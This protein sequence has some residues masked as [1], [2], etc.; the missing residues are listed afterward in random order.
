MRVA[1]RLALLPIIALCQVPCVAGAKALWEAFPLRA[2]PVAG[3]TLHYEA[4][5][6][7]GVDTLERAYRQFLGDDAEQ[8]RRLEAL[9]GKADRI[10][11]HVHEWVGGS[12]TD[13]ER[14][15]EKRLLNLLLRQPFP[16]AAAPQKAT[17]CLVTK[18]AVKDYLRKGGEL[19]DFGYDKASDSALY[20]LRLRDAS[21]EEGFR[22][23]VLA[24]GPDNVEAA[25]GRTLGQLAT[26][27]RRAPAV[28]FYEL[29]KST[30]VRRLRPRDP[31]YRWFAEGFANAVASRLLDAHVSKEA[32]RD[33]DCRADAEKHPEFTNEAN[34][35]HW[36]APDYAIEAP[37]EAE[38]RLTHARFAYATIEA[39][40]L[41][42]R[43]GPAC[44]KKILD[45]T[46]RRASTSAQ[47]LADAILDVTGESI[48]ARFQRYQSFA[49]RAEGVTRYETALDKALRA[50]N[51]ASAL[52]LILRLHELRESYDVHIYGEAAYLLFVL[53]QEA[54]GDRIFDRQFALLERAGN[55]APRRALELIFVDYAARCS[56]LP[57]AYEAAER[58]LRHSPDF[59]PAL[60]AR[61]E[62]LAMSGE[63]DEAKKLA[64]RIQKL[65]K[66]REASA[67][68]FAH[69]ILD[70][71]PK[72]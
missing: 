36:L 23:V 7:R 28:A 46:A 65:E 25:A 31:H 68:R 21:I 35:L 34:L 8:A 53:G 3:S 66:N 1:G 58:A 10:T 6:A 57:K 52:F 9:R 63:L 5:L 27:G 69:K 30:I 11:E 67:W 19:L 60:L 38:K 20:H 39:E 42:S 2:R 22:I 47:N 16:F 48:V 18:A 24:D 72:E 71:K 15:G 49:T 26:V 54:A 51:H 55:D 61:M 14:A 50:G 17:V 44:L 70:A 29:A 43:H 32:A 45:A 12:P 40:R 33:F 56:N 4:S 13:D 59:V 37:L 64:H 41:I 62:R